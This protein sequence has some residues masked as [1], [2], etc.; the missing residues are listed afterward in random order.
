MDAGF[1]GYE[2]EQD[3]LLAALANSDILEPVDSENGSSSEKE[4]DPPEQQAPGPVGMPTPYQLEKALKRPADDTMEIDPGTT[5]K[6][7]RLQ[8]VVD[9]DDDDDKSTN[10][11]VT[12][13][14][15]QEGAQD[16]SKS[17]SSTDRAVT[18]PPVAESSQVSAMQFGR[19]GARIK[20]KTA[21]GKSTERGADK[22]K[23]ATAQAAG[24]QRSSCYC[25]TCEPC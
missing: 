23:G 7:P 21:E 8:E 15:E 6:K 12:T 25:A 19:G 2:A 10:Q 14:V 9:I 1:R 13:V 4:K 11:E 20:G 5:S 17:V 22:G 3:E 16:R 24:N 18:N